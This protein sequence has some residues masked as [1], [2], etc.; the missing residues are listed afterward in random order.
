MGRHFEVRAKSM[1]ATAAKKSAINMRAS[2]EIYMAARSGIPDINNNLALRSVVDKWKGQSVPKDVI[3]RAIKK[4]S[5]G[6]SENYIEGRYEAFGPGG[7]FVIIDTLSDNVNRALSEVRTVLS[8]KGGHLGSVLFN[9]FET[10]SFIFKAQNVEEIE[11]T[12]ILGD[13]DVQEV[14]AEDD[15]INVLVAPVDFQKAKD[16]LSELG[17][18][19]YETCELTLLANEQIE[20]EDPEDRKKFEE[21][22]NALDEIPD[23]QSVYHNVNL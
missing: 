4:A 9:F 22:L 21:L 23:V 10:G 7:S 13:V 2:R 18:E 20:L 8:K 11:E 15:Y 19:E 3:E 17:I 12:L 6:G 1:A 14:S 16:V 5:G